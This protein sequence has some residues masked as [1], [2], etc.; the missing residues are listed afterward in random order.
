[1]IWCNSQRQS[2]QSTWKINSIA[3]INKQTLY[4]EICMRVCMYV[5]VQFHVRM[6]ILFGQK[7]HRQVFSHN[8]LV[9]GATSSCKTG[10]IVYMLCTCTREWVRD[11]LVS[12]GL[13]YKWTVTD[14][15]Y[16][17]LC[18]RFRSIMGMIEQIV[19]M[20]SRT[21]ILQVIKI[22]LVQFAQTLLEAISWCR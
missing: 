19:S 14:K 13:C 9:T 18:V 15:K 21:I 4:N 3:N 6:E 1:M 22:S 10:L 12:A 8:V 2:Q 20:F 5:R 11:A 16:T 7:W 17:E